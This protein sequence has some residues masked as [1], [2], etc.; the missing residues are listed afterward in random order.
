MIQV[1][2]AD[3]AWILLT[4][5]GNGGDVVR[6]SKDLA[7]VY[8]ALCGSGVDQAH[9]RVLVDEPIMQVVLANEGV[10]P[11][12]TALVANAA[13]VFASMSTSGFVGVVV[14]GHGDHQ[15]IATKQPVRSTDLIRWM[16]SVRGATSGALVLG[17]CFAGVFRYVDARSPLPVAIMGAS[18]F[19]SSFSTS[20][21]PKARNVPDWLA[22]PF[23]TYFAD[24]LAAPVDV[25]GDGQFTIIDAYRYISVKTMEFLH[26]SRLTK[27]VYF[28]EHVLEKRTAWEGEADPVRKAALLGELA[29]AVSLLFGRPEPWIMGAD[30][31]RRQ[32]RG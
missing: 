4:S 31:A 17:Q 1:N 13:G 3:A 12:A 23:L 22:N 14:S 16:A 21:I 25:D 19:E 26:S 18:N 9:I 6:F 24:W 15:A 8:E 27:A 30:E 11:A 28:K 32:Q 10:P 29:G 20:G 5:G 7:Y 2:A